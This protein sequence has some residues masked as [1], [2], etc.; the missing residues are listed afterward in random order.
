MAKIQIYQARTQVPTARATTGL[1]QPS[2]KA[3]DF[4][5]G[6]GI[7]TLGQVAVNMQKQDDAKTRVAMRKQIADDRIA[8]AKDV[9]S[10]EQNAELGAPGHT[11]A[12][13]AMVQQRMQQ[14][15][16]KYD[17]RFHDEFQLNYAEI[18]GSSLSGA[19]RFQSKQ[20]GL[21]MQDDIQGTTDSLIEGVV[22][23]PANYMP[24][25]MNDL[26]LLKAN[27]TASGLYDAKLV[28]DAI[29]KE[30]DRI[31]DAYGLSLISNAN[32]QQ[33]VDAIKEDL[34]TR[35][36][37]LS[38]GMT[39][40]GLSAALSFADTRNEQIVAEAKKAEH[41]AGQAKLNALFAAFQN[42]KASGT[43]EAT[44]RLASGHHVQ[45]FNALLEEYGVGRNALS[46]AATR[47]EFL[48]NKALREANFEKADAQK[49]YVTD[50]RM[51]ALKGELS[52]ADIEQLHKDKEIDG[53]AYSTLMNA[54]RAYQRMTAAAD[55][56]DAKNLAK[57]QKEYQRELEKA[58]AE[59]ARIRAK[60]TIVDISLGAI[61]GDKAKEAIANMPAKHRPQA[62]RAMASWAA[63]DEKQQAKDYNKHISLTYER[64]RG[65]VQTGEISSHE[66]GIQIIEEF[67]AK[68][69]GGPDPLAVQRAANNMRALLKGSAVDMGEVNRYGAAILNS[70]TGYRASGKSFTNVGDLK[71]K[72]KDAFNKAVMGIQKNYIQGEIEVG[73]NPPTPD[74][75]WDFQ[76]ELAV[77]INHLPDAFVQ[78]LSAMVGSK[79]PQ[80]IAE[81]AA[82]MMRW[83]SVHPSFSQKFDAGQYKFAHAIGAKLKNGLSPQEAYD[84]ATK[85]AEIPSSDKVTREKV[86]GELS[87]AD[88]QKQDP[89]H[90][91]KNTTPRN[92]N[93]NDE[94]FLKLLEG[95]RVATGVFNA[96]AKDHYMT[97]GDAGGARQFA[98]G[99]MQQ[100]WGITKVSGQ[101][102][103]MRHA[104]ETAYGLAALSGARN[105]Q[106]ISN[107]FKE[108]VEANLGYS[109]DMKDVLVL[110]DPGLTDDGRPTYLA[111]Y[112]GSVVLR[113]AIPDAENNSIARNEK[114]IAEAVAKQ[115]EKRKEA[116]TKAEEEAKREAEQRK[117]SRKAR[118]MGAVR[119]FSSR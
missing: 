62:R 37:E 46:A 64:F 27:L 52:P 114:A 48:R 8:I 43:A 102:V 96:L 70:M 72:K 76:S 107:E 18:R 4:A 23:D 88:G 79:D 34:Q 71:G 95:S 26:D 90:H 29:E 68:H 32:S 60:N 84:Q 110:L 13:E 35:G 19:M 20:S 85:A 59:Q 54:S 38:E 105:T 74:D 33:E 106:W 31:F 7:K 83:S 61:T 22:Q 97:Y 108:A 69:E 104:P 50:Q 41:E 87:K 75:L 56:K 53:S 66:D 10:M 2:F 15:M 119:G 65:A 14:S 109:V 16:S 44:H 36:G 100:S 92:D 21:K 30:R 101:E 103:L 12:V 51:R 17:E 39:P 118:P 86:W 5:S 98:L 45:A 77:S 117:A 1:L 28:N 49:V 3:S 55:A 89:Y 78:D 40:K 82:Q 11:E 24:T 9:L 6:E 42:D 67:Q 111:L 81:G 91:I 115:A 25:A 94:A 47:Q 93:P 63:K 57:Y 116:E 80:A 99:K 112:Q 73:G 113:G 58:N